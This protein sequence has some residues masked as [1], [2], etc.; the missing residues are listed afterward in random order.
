MTKAV[1]KVKKV[2]T[3]KKLVPKEVV[4][5]KSFKDYL[6]VF[7]F[8]FQLPGSKETIKFKPIS[9]GSLKGF[10]TFEGEVEP[11]EVTRMFDK[12]FSEVV[13]SPEDFDPT[14]MYVYDRYALLL[15]IRKKTK[16]ETN[17]FEMKC[18][19]CKGQSVQSVDFDK[20]ESKPMIEGDPII[21]LTES[22]SVKMR[23]LTRLQE[24]EVYETVEQLKVEHDL[25]KNELET[26]TGL[27]LEA[28][29]IDEIIT[30]DGPQ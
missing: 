21:Q 12:L 6:N 15:E 25:S 26:E 7:E 28:Q 23:H 9:I 30:P 19:E 29:T 24:L 4:K 5:Q 16:G 1:S 13:I 27:L 8:L 14:D 18:P 20:I 10:L 22:L 17:Q 11:M 2:T 3:K